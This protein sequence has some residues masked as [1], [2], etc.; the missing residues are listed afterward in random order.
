MSCPFSLALNFSGAAL[1]STRASPPVT[2][3]ALP[4]NTWSS[5]ST[6]TADELSSM[7]HAIADKKLRLTVLMRSFPTFAIYNQPDY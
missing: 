7:Q 6:A 4:D 2:M 3:S 5:T 1:V